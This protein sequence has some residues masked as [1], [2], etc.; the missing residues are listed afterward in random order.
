MW[1]QNACFCS[2]I[3]RLLFD[4][5][6]HVSDLF[7]NLVDF[8]LSPWSGFDSDCHGV[9]ARHCP[10]EQTPHGV[11]FFAHSLEAS[12]VD[13]VASE[14]GSACEFVVLGFEP[15]NLSQHFRY[16]GRECVGRLRV[17]L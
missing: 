1:H 4:V 13:D 15:L 10:V 16:H 6:F 9:N 12:R 3:G 17:G 11:Q 7:S 14:T 5:S 8:E 2:F